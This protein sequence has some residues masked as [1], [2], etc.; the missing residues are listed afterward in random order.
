MKGMI[1]AAPNR[2]GIR[3]RRVLRPGYLLPAGRGARPRGAGAGVA[4]RDG[5]VLATWRMAFLTCPWRSGHARMGSSAGAKG[6]ISSFFASWQVPRFHRSGG[7]EVAQDPA[8]A[9]PG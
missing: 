2:A 3:R 5:C 7:A 6:R 1:A 8:V 4:G 9:A